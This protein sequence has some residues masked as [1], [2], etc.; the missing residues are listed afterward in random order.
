[1][2]KYK[3]VDLLTNVYHEKQICWLIP[4]LSHL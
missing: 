2:N 4:C 1:M 3:D